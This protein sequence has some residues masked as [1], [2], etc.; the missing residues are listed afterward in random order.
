MTETDKQN[1][2]IIFEALRIK[3]PSH[4][5]IGEE[6]ASEDDFIPPL[7]DAPTW[8]VD[9]VD[10]TT[11]FVHSFPLTCVSIG[12]CENKEPVVGVVY[13][14]ARSEMICAVK[15]KGEL[16]EL[17]AGPISSKYTTVFS[18]F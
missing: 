18:I 9:P 17:Y 6:S 2:E 10:G 1:E 12:F 3:F 7:T 15:G 14:P 13:C 8:I 4:I 5:L 16:T 11:N